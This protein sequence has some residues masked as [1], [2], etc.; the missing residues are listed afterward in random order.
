[1]TQVS[2]SLLK[3]LSQLSGTPLAAWDANVLPPLSCAPA[4]TFWPPLD[5]V[6]GGGSCVGGWAANML[7][8]AEGLALSP[9][10]RAAARDTRLTLQTAC[11]APCCLFQRAGGQRG[12]AQSPDSFSA[13]SL[14]ELSRSTLT[15]PPRRSRS[16][17]RLQ[18]VAAESDQRSRLKV[19]WLMW[20]V[21][22]SLPG[23]GGGRR[24]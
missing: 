20:R 17:A 19:R 21:D 23:D 16:L 1:V 11:T 2:V 3:G 12:V 24:R 18:A 22:T 9:P 13:F 4:R 15:P 10:S 14:T 8:W 7:L 5:V 6:C